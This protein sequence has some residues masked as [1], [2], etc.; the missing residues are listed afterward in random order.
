MTT[1]WRVVGVVL[2]MGVL[3]RSGGAARVKARRPGFVPGSLDGELGE[4][5]AVAAVG[6]GHGQGRE[7]QDDA[8]RLDRLVE[9]E[10]RVRA[11]LAGGE[12]L[13]LGRLVGA[14]G[15]D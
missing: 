4:L 13:T 2:V 8:V 14:G 5:D 11:H 15:A 12:D 9:G 6:V 1:S 10:R 3:R 7:P